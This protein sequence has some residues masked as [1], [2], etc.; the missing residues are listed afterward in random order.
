MKHKIEAIDYLRGLSILAIIVIHVLAWHDRSI[1]T[2][3][4]R[5]AYLFSFRDLLQFSVVAV[6]LCSGF[7][8]YRSHSSISLNFAEIRQFYWKRLKRLLIPW[9]G[10]LTIFF[11]V[12]YTLNALFGSRLVDLSYDYVLSSYLMIGGVGFGWLV[13]L[14]IVLSLV[15]PFLKEAY[16]KISRTVL[17]TLICAAYLFSVIVYSA[18]PISVFENPLSSISPVSFASFAIAFVF[19]WSGIYI[20]GFLLED[21]FNDRGKLKKEMQLTFAFIGLSLLV[22][23]IYGV[24]NLN[25]NLYLNKY[26]PTP[27]Y[28]SYG[29]AV[30]FVLLLLFFSYKNFIHEHLRKILA[31]FSSNSY[32]LFMWNALTL[33][34]IIPLLNIFTISNV[35]LKL[36]IDII[37]N[38]FLCS[39][40]VWLQKKVIKLEMHLEKHHF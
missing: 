14:M 35:Y 34:F 6:V 12:H 37:L 39:A 30:T 36:F 13:G 11:A 20:I 19:G 7:S 32:W 16:Q 25:K 3:Y 8:L 29:L 4:T 10:F 1:L 31:F 27:I 40:L 2:E 24:F 9:W 15:F 28:L 26:P 5:I 22:R 18:N 17:L 33:S 21:F 23:L 38:V